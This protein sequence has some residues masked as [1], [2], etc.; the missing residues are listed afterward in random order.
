MGEPH[1]HYNR[2]VFERTLLHE[3]SDKKVGGCK[4]MRWRIKAGIE[5]HLTEDWLQRNVSG[6]DGD[7]LHHHESCSCEMGKIVQAANKKKAEFNKAVIAEI[8]KI[9]VGGNRAE[10]RKRKRAGVKK[11]IIGILQ[12]ILQVNGNKVAEKEKADIIDLVNRI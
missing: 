6:S 3:R 8:Q 11:A 4:D 12:E 1:T 9:G 7:Y 2:S 10:Q 5:A